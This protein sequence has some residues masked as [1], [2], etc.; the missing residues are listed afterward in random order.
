[1]LLNDQNLKKII[2]PLSVFTSGQPH[3]ITTTDLFRLHTLHSFLPCLLFSYTRSRISSQDRLC[4]VSINPK[5]IRSAFFAM[6][7]YPWNIGFVLDF[8]DFE[9]DWCFIPSQG[10][11]KTFLFRI[12]HAFEF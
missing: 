2:R 7:P 9:I 11:V 4:K 1:M 3:D 8:S 6:K 12:F 5:L 10:Q